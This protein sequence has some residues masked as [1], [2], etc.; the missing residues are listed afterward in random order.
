MVRAR[1][2][3]QRVFRSVEIGPAGEIYK[4]ISVE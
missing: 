1:E 2:F 4:R 3:K